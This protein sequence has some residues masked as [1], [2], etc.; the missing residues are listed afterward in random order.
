MFKTLVISI[1]FCAPLALA[2]QTTSKPSSSKKSK[3]QVTVTGC[4]SRQNTDYILMQPDQGNTYELE[5]SS[6]Q[7][8]APYLGQEVEVMG[9]EYPSMATS[10]D[11]LARSGVASPV[12]IRIASIKTI[13]KRCTE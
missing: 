5:R 2:A 10:S 9:T 8:L 4:V 6:K 1:A 13:A 3:D 12:T 11:Y 7:R